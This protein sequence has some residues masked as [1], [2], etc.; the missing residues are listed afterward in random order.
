MHRA[1]TGLGYLAPGI[2]LPAVFGGEHV[3]VV[4]R[5]LQGSRRWIWTNRCREEVVVEYT[6]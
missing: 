2:E 3:C 4:R 6:C 5:E 1:G